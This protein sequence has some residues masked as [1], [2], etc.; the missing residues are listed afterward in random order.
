MLAFSFS[1]FCV[2]FSVYSYL[3]WLPTFFTRHLKFTKQHTANLLSFFEL[4]TLF[5]GFSLGL[6]SDLTYG[7]RSPVILS[8]ILLS[9][10]LSLLLTTAFASLSTAMLLMILFFLGLNLG[11]LHHLLCV[12]C[13]ADLGQKKKATATI[14]GII[15]GTGSL[16]AAAGQ[17]VVGTAVERVGWQKGFLMVVS[18]SIGTTILPALTVVRREAAEVWQ[19]WK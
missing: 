7:K 11:G 17:L 4:G 3:L 16:G 12:T 6:L 14:T 8:A 15:D 2:K 1:F 13:S 9:L 10:L 18:I 5:G 19:T